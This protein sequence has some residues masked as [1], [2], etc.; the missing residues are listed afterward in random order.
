[1][2]LFI[3]IQHELMNVSYPT[4]ILYP[5]YIH[6]ISIATNSFFGNMMI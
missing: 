1:M 6:L 3:W 5:T 2:E 4:V